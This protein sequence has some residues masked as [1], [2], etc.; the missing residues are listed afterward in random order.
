[1]PLYDWKI[2]GGNSLW[3]LVEVFD[4][5]T[6]GRYCVVWHAGEDFID[7]IIDKSCAVIFALQTDDKQ[8]AINYI[9]EETEKYE[10][11]KNRWYRAY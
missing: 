1:M 9:N 7:E 5:S 3:R 10:V 11:T 2:I 6:D 4:E 8:A